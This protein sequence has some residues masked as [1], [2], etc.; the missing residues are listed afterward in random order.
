MRAIDKNN[1]DSPW[2]DQFKHEKVGTFVKPRPHLLKQGEEEEVVLKGECPI[3]LKVDTRT[4]LYLILYGYVQ[5][6]Y[7]TENYPAD[8]C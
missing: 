3:S 5:G 6:L 7:S 2:N 1:L 8:G 4:N